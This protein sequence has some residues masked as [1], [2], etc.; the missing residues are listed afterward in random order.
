MKLP[1]KWPKVVER[2]HSIVKI[3]RTPSNGSNQYTTVYY[4]GEKRVR[5]T[6]S[7]Y[8]MAFTDAETTASTLSR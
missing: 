6:Y 8:G 5:K 2:G 4:L 3:Y 1:K 7:D